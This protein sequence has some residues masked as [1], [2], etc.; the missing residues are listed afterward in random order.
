M[1]LLYLR[2]RFTQFE[3]KLQIVRVHWISCTK[4]D[5]YVTLQDAFSTS[6]IGLMFI[7]TDVLIT[8]L[9]YTGGSPRANANDADEYQGHHGQNEDYID[10]V[11]NGI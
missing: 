8:Q 2:R 1:S 11:I 7:I 10:A 6:D 3:S 4:T 9:G 5:R